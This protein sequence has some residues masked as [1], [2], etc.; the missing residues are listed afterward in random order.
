MSAYPSEGPWTEKLNTRKLCISETAVLQ[1][2]NRIIM[3]KSFYYSLCI[4][5]WLDMT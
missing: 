2:H 3:G 5:I 1:L 4:F